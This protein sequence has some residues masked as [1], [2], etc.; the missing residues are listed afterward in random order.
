[1]PN[2]PRERA[3]VRC[4]RE[5]ALSFFAAAIRTSLETR[6]V[7]ERVNPETRSSEYPRG[8]NEACYPRAERI[9]HAVVQVSYKVGH[10]ATAH[11]AARKSKAIIVG[12]R[13]MR[14]VRRYRLRSFA[15]ARAGTTEGRF[16]E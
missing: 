15:A 12:R 14:F 10:G 3:L 16:V 1:M 9:E 7:G 8:V 2:M 11:T 6:S 5:N 13:G 4:R